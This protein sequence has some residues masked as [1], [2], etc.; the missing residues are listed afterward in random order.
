MSLAVLLVLAKFRFAADGPPPN[1]TGP[2]ERIVARSTYE[3]MAAT[4]ANLMRGLSESVVVL[5]ATPI[6]PDEKAGAAGKKIGV[7]PVTVLPPRLVAAIRVGSGELAIGHVPAGYQVTDGQGLSRPVEVVAVDA[8]RSI[9]VV[10]ATSVFETASGTANSIA[11][12]AGFSYVAV[13]EGAAGGID[14]LAGVRG[15]GPLDR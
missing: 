5:V 1:P 6:P 8:A 12:F 13:V 3:D 14:R 15:A 2:L 9:V 10:R 11:E 4:I 7:E